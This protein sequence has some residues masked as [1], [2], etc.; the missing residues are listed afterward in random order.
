MVEF[1][2]QS[3]LS[4][5]PNRCFTV[6]LSATYGDV[7]NSQATTVNVAD[8]PHKQGMFLEIP[9]A[10]TPPYGSGDV[11]GYKLGLYVNSITQ[12]NLGSN[13]NLTIWRAKRGVGGKVG[14]FGNT[15]VTD[16]YAMS[17]HLSYRPLASFTEN[18]QEISDPGFVSV[19]GSTQQRVIQT[20]PYIRTDDAYNYNDFWKGSQSGY[21]TDF[22]EFSEKFGETL[23]NGLR[24]VRVK[25]VESATEGLNT[26]NTEVSLVHWTSG[27]GWGGGFNPTNWELDPKLDIAWD[28]KWV[29]IKGGNSWT[30]LE[31]SPSWNYDALDKGIVHFE[32]T[33]NYPATAKDYRAPLDPTKTGLAKASS[34]NSG[35]EARLS[36]SGDKLLYQHGMFYNTTRA[37]TGASCLEFYS[38]HGNNHSNI[39]GDPPLPNNAVS[40][41]NY[42]ELENR[43]QVNAIH[44]HDLPA[45]ISMFKER[46]RTSTQE[47]TTSTDVTAMDVT[48][49]F[50]FEKL[51]EV[52][53]DATAQNDGSTDDYPAAFPSRGM[54][55]WFK[56][57][58]DD[59]YNASSKNANMM[60]NI[61]SD[62]LFNHYGEHRGSSTN[63][64]T[65]ANGIT[66]G[67]S[68]CGFIIYKHANRLYLKSIGSHDGTAY[69]NSFGAVNNI[70]E[71]HPAN[72]THKGY[73]DHIAFIPD[74]TGTAES[75][76]HA[77]PV[78]LQGKHVD[79][80]CRWEFHANSANQSR[81]FKLYIKDSNS[82][83]LL[84]DPISIFPTHAIDNADNP[85]PYVSFATYNCASFGSGNDPDTSKAN[86]QNQ[87]SFLGIN[88]NATD[89]EKIVKDNQ[90]TELQVFLDHIYTS[91][92]GCNYHHYNATFS[93]STTGSKL[94]IKHDENVDMVH[95]N[96]DDDAYVGGDSIAAKVATTTGKTTPSILS[97]GFDNLT[98]FKC[99]SA[100]EPKFLYFT[101]FSCD[102]IDSND[103]IAEA[104]IQGFWSTVVGDFTVASSSQTNLR[105]GRQVWGTDG[106]GNPVDAG[107]FSGANTSQF[108]TSGGGQNLYLG[109]YTSSNPTSHLS[110]EHFQQKGHIAWDEH[111]FTN[112]GKRENIFCSARVLRGPDARD[113]LYSPLVEASSPNAE[114]DSAI[115]IDDAT[116]LTN[117][118]DDPNTEYIL[119][120]FNKRFAPCNYVTG[121]KLKEAKL[122]VEDYPA[123]MLKLDK[124]VQ[125]S[126]A[127]RA[128]N[129]F[130]GL[131]SGSDNVQFIASSKKMIWGGAEINGTGG[132]IDLRDYFKKGDKIAV[133]GTSS[134]DSTFTLAADPT[135]AT[136]LVFTTAPTNETVSTVTATKSG[137]DML[138]GDPDDERYMESSRAFISPYK[139]WICFEI[140]NYDSND[141]KLPN[142][143]YKGVILTDF[144]T[145]GSAGSSDFGTDDFGPTWNEWLVSDHPNLLNAWSLSRNTKNSVFY[146]DV[147]FGYGP[148][149]ENETTMMLEGGYVQRFKPE[150]TFAGAA[151]YN[152]I[153][154]SGLTAAGQPVAGESIYLWL[155]S[156][157]PTSTT[158]TNIST[159]LH[160]TST[161]RPFLLTVFDDKIPAHPELTVEPYEE[162]GF[163]P[164]YK[165]DSSE[166]D[167]WYGLLFHDTSQIMNQY[168]NYLWHLPL[169]EDLQ[170]YA[171]TQ[172][173]D[174]IFLDKAGSGNQNPTA[175]NVASIEDRRDGLAGHSKKF[176]A[177]SNTG[178]EF[179]S[180]EISN[181]D[182]DFFSVICH[183]VPDSGSISGTDYILYQASGDTAGDVD[184]CW[185][186]ALTSTGQ[187]EVSVQGRVPSGDDTN[188]ATTLQS[189]SVIPRDNETPT[190]ICFTLDNEIEGQNLKL[191]INGVLEAS[192]GLLRV[193][194]TTNTTTQWA[195]DLHI[196]TNLGK[197]FVACND[198]SG[199]NGYTGKIEEVVA[200]NDVIY[201]VNPR[202]GEFILT[203]KLK[204]FTGIYSTPLS[205][206]A[207]L[208]VKDYHNIRGTSTSDVATSPPV[209]Y[210][211]PV[212]GIRSD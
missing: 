3:D 208:F 2:K 1:V 79:F 202:D 112:A 50:F 106:S 65:M 179:A 73:P 48:F 137:K 118:Q 207:R 68:L 171:N 167:L 131:Q 139:Y 165:W 92:Y 169:N 19:V 94:H 91:G 90:V 34:P 195:K 192:S 18:F 154:I 161:V 40:S 189:S 151:Q 127:Y 87:P 190:M 63:F 76:I 39:A 164:H 143:N 23:P 130:N 46:G 26:E 144:K 33:Q 5:Y 204:D 93:D 115:F 31:D 43:L 13:P 186:I 148:V 145:G 88:H 60:D 45:P 111:S 108:V 150:L 184:Y 104:N 53:Q 14:D 86:N 58:L 140:F 49:S 56:N 21:F 157:N 17:S 27:D 181:G 146:T 110:N 168:H 188:V 61:A 77:L 64:Q 97:F 10:Q 182:G 194:T 170:G 206:V 172:Y 7:F 197:L 176:T 83:K 180:S 163:L 105:L 177:A 201:P 141:A 30:D 173:A 109:N 22:E 113:D 175:I 162:N 70:N 96:D 178:L 122:D 121:L 129:N 119:Y 69:E 51:P 149:A 120:N 52:W 35:T 12:N 6:P 67:A 152:V 124:H 54:A 47:A 134:N 20:D 99:S 75:A 107:T 16:I 114:S 24:V 116:I 123:T 102:A 191:Y 4:V 41:G 89:T 59:P 135:N 15:I 198:S 153:D 158:I 187:V 156:Q 142:K 80:I 95:K 133:T 44:K 11:K 72:T 82:G 81:G 132:D 199:S 185:Y 38:F 85:Y 100:S 117:F 25:A 28:K 62:F 159:F 98:D 71:G 66:T 138:I 32:Y 29:A 136:D 203:K 74:D 205:Y 147:D 210:A 84:A 8:M 36:D 42:G 166:D 128:I 193:H 212:F 126:D 101:D 125:Y 174:L 57:K 103:R 155:T 196:E 160:G 211:K 37:L 55:L 183:I 209:S 200:Y 78:G 9:T